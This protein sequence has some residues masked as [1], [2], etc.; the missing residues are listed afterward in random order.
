MSYILG[1][2]ELTANG[3]VDYS[4]GALLEE[5]HSYTMPWLEFSEN[6][7]LNNEKSLDCWDN[8]TYLV[9]EL[10]NQI[11]KPWVENK[12]VILPEEFAQL[13]A[14]EQIYI[15]DF[16]GL[17]DLFNRAFELKMLKYE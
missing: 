3:K 1:H 12:E 4:I 10:Y 2:T 6:K 9:K 7:G 8:E 5:H 15:E 11:I 14:E 16:Q 13:L 17:Y